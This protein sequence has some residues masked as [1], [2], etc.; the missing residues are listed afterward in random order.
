MKKLTAFLAIFLAAMILSVC[1]FAATPYT[2]Y[3]V[4]GYGDIQETQAAYQAVRAITKFGAEY[5]SGPR[6][7]FVAGDGTIYVA[8]TLNKQILIGNADGDLLGIIGKGT[9]QTPGGVFVTE[10]GHI[11]VADR[12]ARAVFEF[13]TDGELLHTYGKPSSPLYGEEMDFLPLK[14]AVND[15]GILFVVC[16]K[17]IN[18][19]AEISPIDGGTFLGY[20][21]TNFAKVDFRTVLYRAILTREQRA[22]M[23]SNNPSTPDNLAIDERGLVYTVTLGDE[24]KTVKRLNIAGLNLID[25][26]EK[27]DTP[28]A[29]TPG[30]HNNLYVADQ[31]GFIFEFNN[32]GELIFVFG[33]K[34]DGNNRLGLLKTVSAID[35]DRSDRLYILDSALN[36]IQIFKPTE[37]TDKLH[38]ALYLY[39]V[40]RYTESREP[41]QRVLDMNSL[42]DVA[43]RAMGRA[44]FQEENYEEALRYARLAKDREGYSDAYWEIR[45]IWLKNHV[46]GML[47]ILAALFILIRILK[48]LD[49]RKGIFVPVR[50]LLGRKKEKGLRDNL[51][52]A[53]HYMR[54]PI[55]ASYGI[56][57]EGRANWLSSAI[58]LGIFILEFLVNKYL[59]GFLQ[60]T[61]QDGRYELFSDVGIIL[62]AVLGL[63]LC[64]YLVCTINDGE[65][66]VK[67]IFTYFCYSLTP[68][69]LLTPVV[70]LLSHVLTI[71]E[72]FLITF[73]RIIIIGWI[74]VLIV[75]G[76][77]E[78]N[79]YTAKETAKVILLTLFTVLIMALIIFILYI[80]WAQVIEFISAIG[81]EVGYRVNG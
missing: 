5:F 35:V 19:I 78:V 81:G 57:R 30:N 59:C 20:F 29:V 6:D 22:K 61:I 43:N 8:D 40:G 11:Y 44:C 16:E 49:R 60:K 53:F 79:N 25:S 38:E 54:H 45:N 24:D 47:G 66:R 58:L 13:G 69:I 10:N 52:Y 34:D 76:I 27:V 48:T 50:K 12:D 32:E 41:L 31:S 15:A 7:L 37:F 67:Q 21:G 3:T 72:Q 55:D 70:F 73:L 80:L 9:L 64:H 51:G 74:A 77:R 56:A 75:L 23:V 42:F 62:A 2:T 71:N 65:G 28:A 33:G 18:G 68:Y 1:A 36:M 39:S 26:A 17:N 14:V 4:N 46:A 63:T